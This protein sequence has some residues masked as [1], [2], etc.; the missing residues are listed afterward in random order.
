M[1]SLAGLYTALL[2]PFKEDGSINEAALR[3]LV[4]MNIEK[5]V[6]GFYVCGST[7]EAFLL[8]LEERKRI[9]SIV[10]EETAGRVNI[11]CHIGAI[12]TDFSIELGRHAQQVGV[13]AVSS[14]P[15]FYY[16]FSVE[17]IL[18]Y[19]EDIAKEVAL[20]LIPYN[21]PG[22]SGV[23][24]TAGMIA[25]LREHS[26]IVAVKFTS[27]DLYQ[28]QG[29]KANDPNLL[30]FNGF[31]EIFLAGLSMGAD[32]M[33]GSTLNFMAEKYV[34][35][36]KAFEKGDLVSANK[37]QSEANEVIRVMLST[38]KSMNAQK[39]FLEKQNIAGGVSRR[40][41]KPLSPED[42]KALDAV[43]ERYLQ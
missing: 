12:S 42:K 17:E 27:N 14:I 26:N 21:F 29:M 9:L 41:F 20:P 22:L 18:G 3:K 4:S 28:M 8:S 25:S 30:I 7:G 33:I 37:K 13:D 31:D 36:K 34:A 11:F 2:T 24:L 5:G 19:Y 40:P 1:K 39:Y 43:F 10:S 32:G 38:K 23:T 35:I 6:D 15:P 16:K